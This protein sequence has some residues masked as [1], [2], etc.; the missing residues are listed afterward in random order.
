VAESC[1]N[2]T[3]EDFIGTGILRVYLSDL[4]RKSKIGHKSKIKMNRFQNK[5]KNL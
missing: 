1:S 5:F 2:N 4:E 3:N